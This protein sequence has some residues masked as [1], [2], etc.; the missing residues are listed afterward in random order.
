MNILFFVGFI[1]I[2]SI[3]YYYFYDC[4]TGLM[5]QETYEPLWI[6]YKVNLCLWGH[7]HVYER[8]CGMQNNTCVDNDAAPVHV[9]IGMHHYILLLK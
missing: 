4:N 1:I 2:I 3:H 7:V 5:I 9:V 8:T 6:K